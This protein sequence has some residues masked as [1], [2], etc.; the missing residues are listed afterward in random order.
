MAITVHQQPHVPDNLAR[1]RD[2]NRPRGVPPSLHPDV[3]VVGEDFTEHALVLGARNALTTARD[4]ATRAEE[5]ARAVLN[6]Q[7]LTEHARHTLAHDKTHSAVKPGI[8][9]LQ[10]AIERTRGRID[11]LADLL[12]GPKAAITAPAIMAVV[13][14]QQALARLDAKSRRDTILAAL[15]AGDNITALAVTRTMPY[16]LGPGVDDN[17]LEE[18]R[19]VWAGR[20]H[21]DEVAELDALK[22]VQEAIER[23]GSLILGF[24]AALSDPLL[25]REARDMAERRQRAV[26][27]LDAAE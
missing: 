11:A 5:I 27:G 18:F 19:L 22:S 23:G 25:V 12:R 4:A 13:A 20:M 7:S 10:D 16:L 3:L 1:R 17:Q 9:A 14:A 26:A 2:G 15:Q 21:P 24:V 6:D 8:K